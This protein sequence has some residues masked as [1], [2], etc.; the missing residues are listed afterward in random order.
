LYNRFKRWSEKD[1]FDEILSHLSAKGPPEV[2][3]IDSAYVKA[4]RAACSLL[5]NDVSRHIG[6]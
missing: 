4:H 6:A 1:I 2:L 5:K 3:M